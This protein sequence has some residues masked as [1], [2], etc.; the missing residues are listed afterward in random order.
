VDAAL[1]FT[2]GRFAQLLRDEGTSADLVSAILPAADAPGRAARL[3]SE[4][5]SS[6]EDSRLRNL[7]ATLVRITRILP[8]TLLE[9]DPTLLEPDPTLLEPDPTLLERGDGEGDPTLL[10]PRTPRSGGARRKE[11]TEAAELELAA[12]VDAVEGDTAAQPIEAILGRTEHVVAAAA[13]F[14]DEI[15]VNA[16]DENVRAARQ[17]LLAE[18]LSL[19]PA[20]IDWKALDITLG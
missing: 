6:A 5:S 20:D 12:A 14:F 19:A 13:R 15:L 17:S 16:E 4:L 2:V 3:L 8:A 18:I 1:E 7:V 11:L 10:E 9:P